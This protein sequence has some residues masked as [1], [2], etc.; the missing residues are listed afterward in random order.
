MGGSCTTASPYNGCAS[1]P[2]RE[3]VI[4]KVFGISRVHDAPADLLRP[5]S[6]RLDPEFHLRSGMAH[7]LENAQELGWTTGAVD[8]DHIR[9]GFSQYPGG[10]FR[11]IAQD[12]TIVTGK[13]DRYHHRQN[14]GLFRGVDGFTRFVQIVHRL[15]HD[16]VCSGGA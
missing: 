4:A 15:D 16:Q 10:F 7:L 14:K 9:T 5:A 12:R 1:R 3:G 8:S 13:C 6:I 2:E 11:A